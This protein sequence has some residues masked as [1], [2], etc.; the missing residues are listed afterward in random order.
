MG[1]A[2]HRRRLAIRVRIDAK[3]KI[4]RLIR[5]TSALLP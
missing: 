5:L 3:I 4:M 1:T 2:V